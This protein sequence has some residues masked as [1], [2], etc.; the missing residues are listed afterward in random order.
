MSPAQDGEVCFL[1]LGDGDKARN[2]NSP[3]AL[4]FGK[5]NDGKDNVSLPWIERQLHHRKKQ[6]T[7]LELPNPLFGGARGRSIAA[8]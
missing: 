8:E 3:I 6:K 4:S 5:S 1:I 7:N 2:A